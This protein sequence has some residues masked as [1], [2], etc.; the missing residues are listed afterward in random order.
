MVF[1]P[2]H[3]TIRR[4]R[5]PENAWNRLLWSSHAGAA[6]GKE[7]LLCYENPG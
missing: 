7:I 1:F 3:S 2:E 4:F 6:Q 5:P